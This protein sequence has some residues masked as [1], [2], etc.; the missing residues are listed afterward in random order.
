MAD[1]KKEP[2]KEPTLPRQDKAPAPP[3][4]K[5]VARSTAAKTGSMTAAFPAQEPSNK[6]KPA[7]SPPPAKTAAQR[8]AAKTGTKTAAFPA[9]E[10]SKEAKPADSPPPIKTLARSAISKT[11]T[12]TAAFPAQEAADQTKPAHSPQHAAP[13][14][15]VAP[16][17]EKRKHK[18]DSEQIRLKKEEQTRRARRRNRQLIGFAV[19]VL[20]VVGAVSIVMNGIEMARNM[21]DNSDEI[22]MYQNRFKAFVWF[23]T[24]PFESISLMDENSL[25]QVIIWSIFDDQSDQLERNEQDEALVPASEVDRYAGEIFGPDFRFSGHESFEDK[26]LKYPYNPD[27]LTYTV[28]STSL[29]VYFLP[30]VMEVVR[31]P[32]GIR[33]VVMGYVSAINSENQVLATPDF[34][35]PVRYMDYL[36]RRD[37]NGYYLYAIQNNDT[38]ALKVASESGSASVSLGKEAD[39]LLEL[40]DPLLVADSGFSAPPEDPDASA[41]PSQEDSSAA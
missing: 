14:P 30:K 3:P 21:F 41:S 7:D 11:G 1:Q 32:G 29:N 26:D 17:T 31:E 15:P 13:P 39:S 10:A 35:H 8:A 27:T 9:Q 12:M 23:D 16:K 19:A 34:E 28:P 5:T 18:H 40:E 36:L 25:K 22:E 20:V 4:V 37:G 6:A 24:L 33:R 2:Q 38:Y